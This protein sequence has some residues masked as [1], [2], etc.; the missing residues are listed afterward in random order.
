MLFMI[1]TGSFSNILTP[2]AAREVT[3]VRANPAM[4]VSGLGGSVAKVYSADKAT[5]NFGRYEQAN[6]DIVTFDLSAASKQTGTEVSGILG[7]AMLRI[8]DIK[9]DYRDGLVDFY[10]DP[11]HL[12]KGLHIQK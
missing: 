4:K 1:D 7:F 9:I 11:N 2:R 5:L 12:P 6:Q 3:Q 10:Y 8:L